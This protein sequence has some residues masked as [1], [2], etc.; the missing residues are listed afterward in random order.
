[1]RWRRVP[2]Y[3]MRLY[4]TTQTPFLPSIKT[5][6]TPIKR[7]RGRDIDKNHAYILT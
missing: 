4:Y 2:Y 3:A 5:L 7:R 1:V 6:K